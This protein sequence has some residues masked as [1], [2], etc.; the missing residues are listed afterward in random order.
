MRK[1]D[2]IR[3]QRKIKPGFRPRNEEGGELDTEPGDEE[4]KE[5]E[6]EGGVIRRRKK[7]LHES[8]QEWWV[9]GED[10]M[11]RAKPEDIQIGKM[12]DKI[13][14]IRIQKPNGCYKTRT[15]TGKRATRGR[16]EIKNRGEKSA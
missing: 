10:E 13:I 14:E 5:L 4:H 9:W 16:G 11:G 2:A 1:E 8:S 12:E 3:R 7:T 6:I 15:E